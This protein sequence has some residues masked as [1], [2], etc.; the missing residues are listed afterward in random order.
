MLSSQLFWRVFA[1]YAALTIGTALAFVL[2]LAARHRTVID[3]QWHDRLRGEAALLQALAGGATPDDAARDRLAHA[4]RQSGLRAALL[5]GDG[6]TVWSA[7]APPETAELPADFARIADD[8]FRRRRDPATG[9]THWTLLRRLDDRQGFLFVARPVEAGD[10]ELSAFEWRLWGAAATFGLLALAV[11]YVVVGRI[12]G[13][14]ETLTAAAERAATGDLPAE[15]RVESRNEIGALARSFNAMSRELS[16]RISDLQ[17]QRRQVEHNHQRLE[18][19][20]GAMVE[21]VMAIDADERILLANN[22]AIQLLDLKPTALVGRPIWE[23]VRH[24]Q[25]QQLVQQA[26][27][28]ASLRRVEFDVTRTQSTV[29]AAVSRLPGEPCPGVVLVLHDVTELRRL[30][31]LR[32][33]FVQNVSHELKTPLSAIA[34]YADTLL[35]GGLEDDQQKRKFVER[36]AEQSERLSALIGDLL[37]LG[38]M[39][40]EEHAFEV[41]PTDVSRIVTASVEAHRAVAEAKRLTLTAAGPADPVYGFADDDGLRTILDNLLDNAVNYTPAG[42]S[43]AVRWRQDGDAVL[44]EVEDT[45]VGIAKEHQSRIFERF[46]RIDKARSREVGGTGLGLAIVKHLCQVFGGG[47]SV[48]SQLG[49]GTT[50]TVALRAAAAARPVSA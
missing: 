19:V 29:G 44:I 13:P 43:V 28:G 10:R 15:V 45:G 27:A 35:E 36:I 21:G 49:Q 1:I 38:R 30:E 14:L 39:E 31:N 37:A 18:T 8:V 9:A 3:S 42:G 23:A 25:L 4:V 33:E 34:A 5:D 40:S 46:Y 12:I 50:F 2:I 47:V 11:T 20:L 24:P 6:R 41:Q 32:R 26:L 22:A 16:A 7:P 48:S 17:E